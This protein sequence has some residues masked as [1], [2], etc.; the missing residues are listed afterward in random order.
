MSKQSFLS[1]WRRG[2]T[3]IELLI[4][5][6]IIAIL[7]AI[8]VP[9]FLEAQTR[10]KVSRVKNDMRVLAT[11]FE[12]YA[13]DN[14][15]YP[16]DWDERSGFPYYVHVGVSTPIAYVSQAELTD[17][18]AVGIQSQNNAQVRERYRYRAF[19]DNWLSGA[20]PGGPFQGLPDSDDVG[21]IRA[22]EVHGA[23]FLSS[24]GPDG[25]T[26]PLPQGFADGLNENDWLWLKYDS[27]NGTISTGGLIR[28]QKQ[29]DANLV[30]Y[31]YDVMY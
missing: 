11:A 30:G 7:A 27:S 26:L 16:F 19:N 23:W 21:M 15:H 18:F 2:F 17:I 25:S 14:N 20:A 31:P 1:V 8:A 3:L 22:Q 29:G 9:N 12:A 4:V 24:K 6:A 5:V 10:A 13:V 28:S